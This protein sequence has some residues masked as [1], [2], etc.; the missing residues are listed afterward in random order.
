MRVTI[1]WWQ[2]YLRRTNY[3]KRPKPK[4]GSVLMGKKT[5]PF[6]YSHPGT[7]FWLVS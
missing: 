1:T 4:D 2:K 3:D 7:V 5:N 6:V